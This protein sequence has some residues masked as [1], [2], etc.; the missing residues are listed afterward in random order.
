MWELNLGFRGMI[1]NY[2]VINMPFFLV[3]CWSLSFCGVCSCAVVPEWEL[4][5][6]KERH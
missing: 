3:D 2:W 5:D 1:K 6:H 4:C